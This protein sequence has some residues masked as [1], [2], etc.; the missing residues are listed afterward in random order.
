MSC[1]D[2]LDTPRHCIRPGE[3]F[4]V[5]LC[6]QIEAEARLHGLPP[7]YFARLL[8]Q[9]SR[10]DPNAVSPAN[11]KG[12][13]QFI[14]STARL[15]GLK[16]PFNP[17]EA[18]ARAAEYLGEMTRR[19]G[20]LGHAAIGYN[21]GERR[22]EGW[23]AGTGGLARETIDYVR[24]ITGHTAETW[25]DAPPEDETFRLDGET[26]FQDACVAMAA[27]RRLTPLAPPP[28]RFAAWGAQVTFGNDAGAARA[29]YG[30]LPQ[31]CRAAAPEQRLEFIPV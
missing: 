17:A 12:I 24:I 9:E 22:A 6:R 2:G 13:A 21:G 8:W 3:A 29:A 16:D 25:R 30:R 20:N 15:R 31:A 28:P 18:V 7:G 23:I 26:P 27:T 4:A 19:Y 10:F 5:D 1:S 14:D 11:A